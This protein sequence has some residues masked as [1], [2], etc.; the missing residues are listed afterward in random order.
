MN[1]LS[2]H[3]TIVKNDT[4]IRKQRYLNTISNKKKLLNFNNNPNITDLEQI[5]ILYNESVSLFNQNVES[6]AGSGSRTGVNSSV[7]P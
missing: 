6:A 4:L 7:V 2:L 1:T 3:E 5:R